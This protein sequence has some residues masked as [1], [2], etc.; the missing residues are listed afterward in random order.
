MDSYYN[1]KNSEYVQLYVRA[2]LLLKNLAT[3]TPNHVGCKVTSQ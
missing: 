2:N 1:W 3:N